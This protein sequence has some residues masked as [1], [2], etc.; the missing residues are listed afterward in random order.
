VEVRHIN[1]SS[2][3][4]RQ[5]KVDTGANSEYESTPALGQALGAYI[6][7]TSFIHPTCPE[8]TSRGLV[9][10]PSNRAWLG[11]ASRVSVAETVK[12]TP[13]AAGSTLD[14]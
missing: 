8:S 12:A 2:S 10:P 7:C 3:A 4:T 14:R 1:R 13:M 5:P 9:C 6:L 11:I